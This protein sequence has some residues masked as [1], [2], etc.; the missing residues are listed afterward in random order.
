MLF[1]AEQK[2]II[3]VL[4]NI[5]NIEDIDADYTFQETTAGA[6]QSVRVSVRA[7]VVIRK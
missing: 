7:I 4:A 6:H 1:F 2:L 3:E 5:L